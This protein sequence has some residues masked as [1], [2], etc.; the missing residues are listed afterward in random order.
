MK[1][2]LLLGL[3][4]GLLSGQSVQVY[5]EFAQLNDAGEAVAPENPRE[6][7]SPAV[8][9]NAFSSFQ[10][11][12][13]VPRGVK[14]LVYIGQ[15]PDNAAKVALYRREGGKL[16]PVVMPYEGVSSEVLWMDVWVDGDAPVRRVKI[17]P[18]VGIGGEWLT[19]PM[20]VRVMEPVVTR[21]PALRQAI[22]EPFDVMRAFLCGGVPRPLRGDAAIG[23]E[24]RF[25]NARQDVALAAGSSDG[26]REEITKAMG[27]CTAPAPADLEFYLR[28]RDLLLRTR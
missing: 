22:A 8:A 7:L 28:V 12:I 13:Q 6:I 4:G 19:Y 5:S 3:A 14:F 11:V 9:R 16:V 21:V 2:A 27:G 15:N 23:A 1:W 10:L 20:E 18:Q 24:Q 26:L 25:R 17:E